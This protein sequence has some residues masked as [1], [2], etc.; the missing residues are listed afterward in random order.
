MI[1][2]LT[3]AASL[4]LLAS[5]PL[6]ASAQQDKAAACA[7][8]AGIVM[9]AVESRKEGVAKSK[10]RAALRDQIGDRG[11]GDMLADWIWSLPEDQLT[12][13]VGAAW[14]AQCLAQ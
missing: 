2:R 13:E 3:L 14:E 4:G 8:S 6:A 7:E 9:Q 12:D 10:A 5:L 11:A 1:L